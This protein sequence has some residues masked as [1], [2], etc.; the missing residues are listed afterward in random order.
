[1][2]ED[3]PMYAGWNVEWSELAESAEALFRVWHER[4]EL[5]RA[6]RAWKALAD[7]GL[8]RWANAIDHTQVMVRLIT[9]AFIYRDFCQRGLD[10]SYEEDWFAG[11]ALDALSLASFRIGQLIGPGHDANEV[12][13]EDC[14]LAEAALITLSEAE[15]PNICHALLK[16]FGGEVQLAEALFATSRRPRELGV[17]EDDVE[18]EERDLW[19]EHIYDSGRV[20]SWIDSGM[21][22]L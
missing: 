7:A 17:D 22:R 11:E 16:A 3:A 14:D 19:D 4:T 12:E 21:H 18:P 6:E 1:M 2:S 10:E 20:L 15:R 8:T 9:L 13:I 5:Q